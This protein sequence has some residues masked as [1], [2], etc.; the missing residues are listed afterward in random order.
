[1]I[2]EDI[3]HERYLLFNLNDELYATPLM[4]VREVVEVQ[5]PKPVPH[6]VS[7]FLGVINIRGEIVGVIDLRLRFQ[8]EV[9]HL[10]SEAMMVFETGNGAIAAIVDS[11]EGVSRIPPDQIERKPSIEARMPLD[12]LLGV[13]R[14]RDRL[15]TII[16]LNQILQQEEIKKIS[17]SAL[18]A[19]V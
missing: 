2:P 11:M 15:V 19:A 18:A 12:F 6:T 4:G 1:M 5:K 17:H 14:I 9:R 3:D 8:Y 16:D 7:S 10:A 13:G